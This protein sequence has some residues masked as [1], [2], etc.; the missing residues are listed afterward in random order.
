MSWPSLRNRTIE[1]SACSS[2]SWWL[3]SDDD[4]TDDMVPAAVRTRFRAERHRADASHT[5]PHAENP[6]HQGQVPCPRSCREE[7]LPCRSR[8]ARRRIQ[9]GG[10]QD[11][12]HGRRRDR[13][14]QAD[15]FA[16]DPTVTPQ[17][18]VPGHLQHQP[19]D[20]RRRRWS[21]RPTPR[22]GPTDVA[23]IPRASAASCAATRS[24]V[25]GPSS[26]SI[27]PVPTGQ[28][29]QPR[30]AAVGP[31]AS[32]TRR[33]DDAARGSPRPGLAASDRKS[34]VSHPNT[35]ATSR[36]SSLIITACD[37]E[38]WHR[39]P[40][41]SRGPTLHKPAGQHLRQRFR[42]PQPSTDA[43]SPVRATTECSH[44][45]DS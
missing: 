13:V 11:R 42:H 39:H 41:G 45:G 2:P 38:A 27:A 17:R 8:P 31:P 25:T 35:R 3:P 26:V 34:S 28:R 23:P 36:Y 9:P 30:S 20:R 4:R 14:P 29:D 19:A 21:A 24:T 10:L 15:E 43:L 7:L 37:H 5:A 16:V 18:V 32:A 1:R 6:I 22:I 40:V 33:V 12:P 44:H